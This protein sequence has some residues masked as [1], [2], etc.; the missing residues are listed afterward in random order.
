MSEYVDADEILASVE[1]L[2]SAEQKRKRILIDL[3]DRIACGEA[4]TGD[5]V[6]DF[7]FAIGQ[8]Q[9]TSRLGELS[10]R[11]KVAEG[12]NVLAITGLKFRLEVEHSTPPARVPKTENYCVT[13][14]RFGTLSDIAWSRDGV[15]V[16]SRYGF[17]IQEKMRD[18]GFNSTSAMVMGGAW[19]AYDAP[20][21]LGVAELFNGHPRNS[22][23]F[24]NMAGAQRGEFRKDLAP[25]I[26]RVL[27]LGPFHMYAVGSPICT[28]ELFIGNDEVGRAFENQ[29]P[30]FS[31]LG[32]GE[33]SNARK[34][35]EAAKCCAE[36]GMTL[37]MFNGKK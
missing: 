22:A 32:E 36:Q 33:L 2:A 28:T 7:C 37:E 12:Q 5:P 30:D 17:S 31:K 24:L 3:R 26:S 9:E 25:E 1:V 10:D 29:Y 8:F 13:F 16:S 20:F 19:S 21:T 14:A 27:N 6:K 11:L 4:T 23:F 18:F 34:Q 15:V 35:Y